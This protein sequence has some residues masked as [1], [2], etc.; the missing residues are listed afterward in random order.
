M[1]DFNSIEI[2]KKGIKE[3]GIG[4]LD[5]ALILFNQATDASFHIKPKSMRIKIGLEILTVQNL[6]EAVKSINDG[7]FAAGNNKYIKYES[8]LDNYT[9]ICK[10]NSSD[11][12]SVGCKYFMS[13]IGE[14]TKLYQHQLD[15][16]ES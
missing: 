6:C 14:L 2:T 16:I 9:E 15:Q 12:P 8:Y 1:Y 3:A 7:D 11:V 13:K 10:T 5:E 4:N